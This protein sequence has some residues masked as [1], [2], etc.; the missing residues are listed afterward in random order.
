MSD[1]I[2]IC[3][4]VVETDTYLSFSLFT[5]KVVSYEW[6]TVRYKKGTTVSES[7]NIV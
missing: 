2:A 4:E 6:S 7:S 5:H 1:R 3:R